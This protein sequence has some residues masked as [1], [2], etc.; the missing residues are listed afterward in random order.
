M[1]KHLVK[2]VKEGKIQEQRKKE[3]DADDNR[4]IR[5]TVI[6]DG[7]ERDVKIDPNEN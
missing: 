7:M 1:H 4:Q 2:K 6:K 5:H 3:S